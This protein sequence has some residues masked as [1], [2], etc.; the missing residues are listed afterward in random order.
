MYV[1]ANFLVY[2]PT[3]SATW[4][5]YNIQAQAG[6]ILVLWAQQ[7]LH[8]DTWKGTVDLIVNLHVVDR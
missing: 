2:N 5:R 3:F 8:I 6:L 4:Q 1:K 7:L